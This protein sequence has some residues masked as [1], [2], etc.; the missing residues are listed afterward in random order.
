MKKYDLSISKYQLKN[1]NKK[2]IDKIP[3]KKG[4]EEPQQNGTTNLQVLCHSYA[5][6][7]FAED[8]TE[9]RFKEKIVLSI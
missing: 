1:K 2:K 9:R 7:H 8:H 5:P 3:C 6:V 4:G